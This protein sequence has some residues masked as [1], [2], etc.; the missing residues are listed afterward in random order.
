MPRELFFSG[1]LEKPLDNAG[2]DI[3][4]GAVL[5]VSGRDDG[6]DC[7]GGDFAV[8]EL[9]R[10]FSGVF[11]YPRKRPLRRRQVDLQDIRTETPEG[12]PPMEGCRRS[13][14]RESDATFAL[15]RPESLCTPSRMLWFTPG[16]PWAG[17]TP[18]WR[19]S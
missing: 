18:D 5:E 9:L 14:G 1:A 3:N 12:Q 16:R 4:C 13:F 6:H 2:H 19:Q 15:N 7:A 17:R 8:G 11:P 10:H